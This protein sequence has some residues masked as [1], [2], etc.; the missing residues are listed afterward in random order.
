[1]HMDFNQVLIIQ[2]THAVLMLSIRHLIY[3]SICV[4]R[5]FFFFY[6][7]QNDLYIKS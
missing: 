7:H 6:E 5:Q 4:C 1:M 3:V 2:Q